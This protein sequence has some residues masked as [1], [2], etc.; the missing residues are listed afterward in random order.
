[1]KKLVLIFAAVVLLFSCKSRQNNTSFISDEYSIDSPCPPDGTCSL[2]VL[3]DKSLLIKEDDTG[4]LFYQLQDT[5]GKT[6]VIY[7]Y[8]KKKNPNVTDSGYSEEVIFETD[9]KSTDTIDTN[10]MIFGVHCFCRGKAGYYKAGQATANFTNGKLYI[11][12]PNIVDGQ[13]TKTIEVSFK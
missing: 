5:D 8:Q 13:K 6:V 2:E 3:Q 10:R 9:N 4:H 11:E 1:M 12:L 7:K